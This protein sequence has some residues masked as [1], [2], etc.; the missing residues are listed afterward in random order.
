MILH[1]KTTNDEQALQVILA[2]SFSNYLLKRTDGIYLCIPDYEIPLLNTFLV[3]AGIGLI[4]V[5]TRNALEDYFLQVTSN[6]N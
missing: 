5:E 1:I 2:G 6:T 4:G 3:N